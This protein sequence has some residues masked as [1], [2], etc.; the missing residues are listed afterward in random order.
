MCGRASSLLDLGA[1]KTTCKTRA[2]RQVNAVPTA[3]GAPGQTQHS[4][5][6][7][8]FPYPMK[9][10][11]NQAIE[12]S[13]RS[14][15]KI[16]SLGPPDFATKLSTVNAHNFRGYDSLGLAKKNSVF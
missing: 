6:S 12:P 14:T 10:L 15:N 13:P 7:T 11:N 16:P 8:T 5:L 9:V 4:L 1:P 2:A 3:K